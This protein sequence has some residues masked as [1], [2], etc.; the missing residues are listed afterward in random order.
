MLRKFPS[1][2]YSFPFLDAQ[3]MVDAGRSRSSS[4][5]AS[6]FTNHKSFPLVMD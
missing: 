3:A 2:P 1:L 6:P 4:T 5:P